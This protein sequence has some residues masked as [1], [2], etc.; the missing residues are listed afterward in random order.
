MPHLRPLL[1]NSFRIAWSLPC[2]SPLHM[3]IFMLISGRSPVGVDLWKRLAAAEY[4]LS[5]TCISQSWVCTQVP[6]NST[7]KMTHRGSTVFQI[8]PTAQTGQEFRLCRSWF[9]GGT[10]RL[11]IETYR[12]GQLY[13]QSKNHC[14]NL[15]CSP[16]FFFFVQCLWALH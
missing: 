13:P 15:Q 14:T 9:L 2:L 10:S 16:F 3:A 12:S 1:S 8:Q 11:N 6:W 4:Q 7:M 5:R